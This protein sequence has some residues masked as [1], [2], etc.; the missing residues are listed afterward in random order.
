MVLPKRRASLKVAKSEHC[1][2]PNKGG[3]RP[4]EKAKSG[5]AVKRRAG[6]EIYS[7]TECGQWAE[8]SKSGDIRREKAC[9]G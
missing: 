6:R 4:N 2:G 5:K 1:G 3:Q 7:R 8:I 9:P